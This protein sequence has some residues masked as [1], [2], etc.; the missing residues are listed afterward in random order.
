MPPLNLATAPFF[1]EE[2]FEVRGVEGRGARG[3]LVEREALSTACSDLGLALTTAPATRPP[4][5]RLRPLELPR[6]KSPALSLASGRLI[7]RSN[8]RFFLRTN[9][10]SFLGAGMIPSWS[11]VYYKIPLKAITC[12]DLVDVPGSGKP[13]FRLIR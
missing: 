4:P 5:R 9:P 6:R 8:T 7:L 2:G 11:S 1:A 12:R 3:P 13:P 10:R